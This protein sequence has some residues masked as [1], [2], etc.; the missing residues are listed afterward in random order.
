M[1]RRVR[2]WEKSKTE[3]KVITV[4]KRTIC[5][6]VEPV[7]DRKDHLAPF[8]EMDFNSKIYKRG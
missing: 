3:S 7:E 6:T 5:T 8:N 2:K 1:K 4:D